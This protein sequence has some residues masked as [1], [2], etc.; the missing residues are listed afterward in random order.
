VSH[1]N[2]ID[3]EVKAQPVQVVAPDEDYEMEK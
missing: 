2:Q 1:Q 3:S